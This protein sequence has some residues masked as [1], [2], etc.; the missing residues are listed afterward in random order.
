MCSWNWIK[1]ASFMVCVDFEMTSWWVFFKIFSRNAKVLRVKWEIQPDEKT[2]YDFHTFKFNSKMLRF[3]QSRLYFLKCFCF[4]C[5]DGLSQLPFSPW[6]VVRPHS[7]NKKIPTLLQQSCQSSWKDCIFH[8]CWNALSMGDLEIRVKIPFQCI[9]G[10][11]FIKMLSS[12][13]FSRK[14]QNQ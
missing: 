9:P 10:I 6:G 2:M 7:Q 3:D 8:W 5:W 11:M 4:P 14:P 1:V 13:K 12:L